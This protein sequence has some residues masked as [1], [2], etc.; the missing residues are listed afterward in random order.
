MQDS[1]EGN[2]KVTLLAFCRVVTSDQP[3]ARVGVPHVPSAIAPAVAIVLAVAIAIL[4]P[5]LSLHC[6]AP[7]PFFYQ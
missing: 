3:D 5:L 4:R 7:P 2:R 1:E 6:F